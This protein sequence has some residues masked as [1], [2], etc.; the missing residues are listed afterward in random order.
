MDIFPLAFQSSSQQRQHLAKVCDCYSCYFIDINMFRRKIEK[1]TSSSSVKL[2]S[3]KMINFEDV[4]NLCENDVL[5]NKKKKVHWKISSIENRF[6]KR[7]PNKSKTIIDHSHFSIS[8]M[9]RTRIF[10]EIIIQILSQDLMKKSINFKRSSK[11]QVHLLYRLILRNVIVVWKHFMNRCI[12]SM[13]NLFKRKLM[14]IWNI[15]K[16]QDD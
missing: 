13:S 3:I 16:W 6:K 12:E 4:L 10:M 14:D 11:V 9:T 5:G 2:I 1:K 7:V 15:R 8:R